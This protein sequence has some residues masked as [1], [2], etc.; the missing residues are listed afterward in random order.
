M[1]S[2]PS[3][4]LKLI[5]NKAPGKKLLDNERNKRICHRGRAFYYTDE[6]DIYYCPKGLL[7]T[8]SHI[9]WPD[10]D[11]K[12]ITKKQKTYTKP[13]RKRGRKGLQ[14]NNK[15]GFPTSQKEKK[16]GRFYGIIKGSEVHEEIQDFIDLDKKSF[17]KK[18]PVIHDFTRRILLFISERNWIPFISEFM[19]FDEDIRVATSIDLVC[20]DIATGK[21][22]FLE[23]KTGYE[24]YFD[25]FTGYMRKSL[26][27]LTNSP[28]NQAHVQLITSVLIT[29]KSHRISVDEFEMYVIR[30]D[31]TCLSPNKI[32]NKYLSN[33]ATK[34]YADLHEYRNSVTTLP[35]LKSPQSKRG[36]M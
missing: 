24:G 31:N 23:F 17:L 2:V 5:R 12:E 9:Y 35:I 26:S 32:S 15:K 10:F 34:I 27:K 22:I 6:D 29:M 7:P 19:V 11:A 18:H 25:R 21:V 28:F 13:G 8:L 33:K 1:D 30:V 16:R 3:E 20:L 14:E 36:V 4:S